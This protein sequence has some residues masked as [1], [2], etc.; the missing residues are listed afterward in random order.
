LEPDE[1]LLELRASMAVRG[2]KLF[3]GSLRLLR[4]VSQP[5]AIRAAGTTAS[6][7]FIQRF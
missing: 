1:L 2:G 4:L 5:V 3:G 7:H 6:S